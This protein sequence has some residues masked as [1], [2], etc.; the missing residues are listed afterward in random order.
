[1]KFN[2]FATI[3]TFCLFLTKNYPIIYLSS[4][5]IKGLLMCIIMFLTIKV[6]RV[7]SLD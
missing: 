2:F 6:L 4:L 3:G 7:L 5:L 1:M